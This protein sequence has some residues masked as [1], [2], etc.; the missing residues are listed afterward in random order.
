MSTI[1]RNRPISVNQAKDAAQRLINSHFRKPNSARMTIPAKVD[2]DDILLM[3]YLNQ[4]ALKWS[5]TKPGR[6]G[7]WLYR[8]DS[9]GFAPGLMRI[10]ERDI[11]ADSVPNW[12][13]WAGPVVIEE[14]E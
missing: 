5:K 14:P 2:D 6:A 13:E 4:S 1:D 11:A 12:F 10:K 8:D 3:D 9:P 7:L